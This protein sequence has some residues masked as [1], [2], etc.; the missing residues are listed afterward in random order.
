MGNGWKTKPKASVLL[1]AL[2]LV[3]LLSLVSYG[4]LTHHFITVTGTIKTERLYR[5]KTMQE[6]FFVYYFTLPIEERKKGVVNF[7]QGKCEFAKE[8]DSLKLTIRLDKQSFHF[9]VSKTELTKLS[10]RF[11]DN[12]KSVSD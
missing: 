3:A 9:L 11:K 10:Q 7:S 4:V 5:A 8:K 1:S 2:L 6:L 12:K